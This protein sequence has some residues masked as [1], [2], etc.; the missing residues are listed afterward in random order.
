MIEV[1]K[2]TG[3]KRTIAYPA[4][5]S[6]FG[7]ISKALLLSVALRT[8]LVSLNWLLHSTGVT[9]AEY[10]LWTDITYSL[11]SWRVGRGFGPHDNEV[12]RLDAEQPPNSGFWQDWTYWRYISDWRKFGYVVSAMS[13]STS[14]WTASKTR[15]SARPSVTL[16]LT[17][18]RTSSDITSLRKNLKDY[19][20][21]Y[22][23]SH[24]TFTSY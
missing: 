22:M 18:L 14:S 8:S 15:L 2:G 19:F 23:E 5:A 11:S 21:L 6:G 10:E 16:R 13:C 9:L 3:G 4:Y 24:I 1:A 20:R 17:S 7:R 12:S